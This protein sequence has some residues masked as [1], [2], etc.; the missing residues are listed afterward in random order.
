M[1]ASAAS[2]LKLAHSNVS[3]GSLFLNCFVWVLF[4]VL[5]SQIVRIP[6]EFHCGCNMQNMVSLTYEALPSEPPYTALRS[7]SFDFCSSTSPPPTIYIPCYNDHSEFFEKYAAIMRDVEDETPRRPRFRQ[8]EPLPA[9]DSDPRFR[10]KT[11]SPFAR[12]GLLAL[13]IVL[14]WWA[15]HLRKGLWIA[16][17]MGMG[18]QAEEVLDC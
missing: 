6:S 3:F 15:F 14:F 2:K 5:Q 17:G 18:I 1:R 10:V 9:F 8:A 7:S 16:T 13:I 12:A 11:P 4:T